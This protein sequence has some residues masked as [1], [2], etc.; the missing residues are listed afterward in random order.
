MLP[1][2]NRYDYSPI[3]DRPDWSWPEG[4][5]LAVYIAVNVEHFAFGT[6]LGHTPVA[7]VDPQ[8]DVRSFA[9]RDYG[10]RVGIW[11]LFDVLDELRLPATHLI[12]STACERYPQVIRK[13][14]DR[15][16]DF[17]SHGRT[18]AERQGTLSEQEE[19]ELIREATEV[20]EK[21]M[22]RHPAGWMGP[23]RSESVHTSDLLKEAGY[24]FSMDWPCDDQPIWLKTRSGPLLAVP[25]PVEINDNPAMVAKAHT[26][27]EF[28]QMIED[29]FEQMLEDSKRSPLVFPISVHT[30]VVGQ[31]FRIRRLRK[32]FELISNHPQRD[33]VWFTTAGEIARH[34]IEL[35]PGLIAGS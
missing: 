24:S 29:N 26:A 2:H 10:L 14:K 21:H 11:R 13:I 12:N 5:R 1:H 16:D 23:W 25:Y 20:L 28:T 3:V 4:K 15:N 34:A 18:N 17:V 19:A 7:R 22:G 30:F 31:P 33:T 32:A 8:P 6:G 9:W 35:P 27:V